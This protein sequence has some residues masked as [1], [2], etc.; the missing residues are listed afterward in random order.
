MRINHKQQEL[1]DNFY[2]ITKEKFP[3][4]EYKDLSTSPDDPEH[5]D[6]CNC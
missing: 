6:K 5:M 2:R 4:I 3:E 1:I